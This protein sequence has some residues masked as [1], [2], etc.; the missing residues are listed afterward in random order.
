MADG[1]DGARALEG[2]AERLLRHTPDA[3]PV[4]S[5][6]RL[7]GLLLVPEQPVDPHGHPVDGPAVC[8]F[9]EVGG[10][11]GRKNGRKA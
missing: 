11:G 5:L 2:V 7:L 8:V 6:G 9:G 10:V 4:G 1:R 3:A